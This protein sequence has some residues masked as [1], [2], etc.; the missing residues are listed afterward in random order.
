LANV[1]ADTNC[2]VLVVAYG[3]EKRKEF[4]GCDP[5]VMP[6]HLLTGQKVENQL[7]ISASC[8]PNAKQIIFDLLEDG[9]EIIDVHY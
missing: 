4:H 3:A 5:A 9:K 8:N 2:M 6:Y 7:Q 1:A